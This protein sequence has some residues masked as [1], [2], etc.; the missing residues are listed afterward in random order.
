MKVPL[1]ELERLIATTREGSR[2]LSELIRVASKASVQSSSTLIG[3]C[4]GFVGIAAAYALTFVAPVPFAVLS[5]IC[6]GFGIAFAILLNR[7]GS[8]LQFERK[9][10]ENR[11]AADEIMDRIKALPRN[12][13]KDVRD[14]LW[15]T[16]RTL[17]S[18]ATA[19]RG[20]QSLPSSNLPVAVISA[21]GQQTQR[22]PSPT[23]STDAEPSR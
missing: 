20:M 13:P 8:R 9:L 15:S 14:E 12:A 22:L 16:Y 5:P 23:D 3:I 11:I 17:N 2:T 19:S 18:M 7:G 10:E 4:G 1:P 21:P 6:S